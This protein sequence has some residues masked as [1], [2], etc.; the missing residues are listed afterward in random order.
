[1]AQEALPRPW[2]RR[3]QVS[4][5]TRSEEG[6]VYLGAYLPADP[7]AAEP[8]RMRERSLHDVVLSDRGHDHDW[9]R[10]ASTARGG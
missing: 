9:Y 4:A 7:Q 3:R 6:F 8:V 2:G 5:Y 10:R 1:M